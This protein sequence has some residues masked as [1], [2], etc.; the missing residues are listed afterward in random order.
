[1]PH[2]L[3]A[4]SGLGAYTFS[5][6]NTTSEQEFRATFVLTKPRPTPALESLSR[7]TTDESQGLGDNFSEVL[8]VRQRSPR[9]VDRLL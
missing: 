8:C 5:T 9:A 4:T 6:Y 7:W 1:M 3:K 2:A